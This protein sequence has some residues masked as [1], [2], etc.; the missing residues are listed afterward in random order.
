MKWA[1]FMPVF[2]ALAEV[3]AARS[4]QLYLVGGCVR[5]HI[6][7]IE[8]KDYDMA[9]S[10]HPDATTEIL[11]GTPGIATVWPLGERFGTIAAKLAD[12]QQIEI[13][14]FRRDLT[15]GRHPDVAFAKDLNTDL[16]RRDFRF[17][18]MA[19]SLDGQLVDPFG[20]AQDLTL[21]RIVCTGSPYARFAEDPLRM[22]RA[23]RFSARFGFDLAKETEKAIRDLR[24]SILAV[25]RERWLEEM[26]KLLVSPFAPGGI[27][28]LAHTGLLWL[29]VPEMLSVWQAGRFETKAHKDLWHHTRTV[30]GRTPPRPDVRWSA[31]L[32]DIAKPHTE[33]FK[34]GKLHF[35]GHDAMGAEMA[36]GIARRLKM[37]NDRRKSI[38]GL[39]HLHQRVS[40][41]MEDSS[42]A[43]MRVLRRL[44]RECEE[45]GCR[46]EDL[47]DLFGADCSSAKESKRGLVAEQHK[48]LSEALARMREEDLRPRL[49]AGIGNAIMEKFGLPPGPEVGVLRQKLDDMLVAGDIDQDDSIDSMLSRLHQEDA[50]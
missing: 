37:S 5:D 50:K 14:T 32:H 7:G 43:S 41:A 24:N 17:N 8:P 48:A 25:S 22:L 31:L 45:R 4:H 28:H 19:F 46:I 9:T 34:D 42:T 49:P 23:V 30:V 40:A 10:A 38:C 20:G 11:K 13:T 12:G 29:L 36:S 27:E 2:K 1:E 15:P 35:L 33:G 47:I 44:V 26:D 21:K 6:L 39:I 16:E 3:F 18:S